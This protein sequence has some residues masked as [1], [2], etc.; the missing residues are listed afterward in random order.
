MYIWPQ[1]KV[2]DQ[3]FHTAPAN[4][5]VVGTNVLTGALTHIRIYIVARKLQN[6]G[7]PAAHL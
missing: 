7:V 5:A 4:A 6:D 1:W 2:V 3:H